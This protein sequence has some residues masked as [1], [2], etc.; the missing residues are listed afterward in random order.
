MT[1]AIPPRTLGE[2]LLLEVLQ[3]RALLGEKMKR[4]YQKI[5]SGIILL[6]AACLIVGCSDNPVTQTVSEQMEMMQQE[7]KTI[8]SEEE[9]PHAEIK[10]P[11]GELKIALIDT[12]IAMKAVN[13]ERILPHM[14]QLDG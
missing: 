5:I 6:G 3:Y 9:L 2:L 7:E 4:M 11:E 8:Q 14:N 10:Q 1:K 13:A 12:G